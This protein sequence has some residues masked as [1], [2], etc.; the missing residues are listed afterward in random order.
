MSVFI[1]GFGISGYRSFGNETQRIAPLDKINL[2]I[3]QNNSEIIW[4][5]YDEENKPHS[6]RSYLSKQLAEKIIA[7]NSLSA[8]DLANFLRILNDQQQLSSTYSR[9]EPLSLARQILNKISPIQDIA[10]PEIE[11]IPAIRKIGE[12]DSKADDYSGLGI[13]DTLAKLQN[14]PYNQQG[15]KEKF[16]QI[17]E[18][19]REVIDNPTAIL[20]IPYERDMILVHMDDKTLPLSS[21]GMGIHEV[22]ILGAAATVLEEQIICIEELEIHLHPIL[23][24]KLIRYLRDRTSNQYFITTHSAHLLDTPGAAIFHV[25]YQNGQSFVNLVSS[26]ND[27]TLIC[28]DLGYHASDLLQANCIIWVEGPSDRIYLKYWIESIDENLT[29]GIHY[30]IMFYGGRLLSHLSGADEFDEDEIKEFINLKK[31]NRYSAIMIDSDKDS[32]RKHI[33]QTK[34]RIKN[35][36]ES[37]LG[38]AWITQGREVENYID[39]DILEAA[40]KKVH[41][42]AVALEK[43]GNYD[44]CLP[45]INKK[46]KINSNVN[47][48]KVAREVIERSPT[49]DILDLKSR[50]NQTVKFIKVSNGL[51]CN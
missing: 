23:Q 19:V 50:I 14:P 48:V 39:P 25:K 6:T 10:L 44:N 49:L 28:T 21:L 27:K 47:K 42:S 45:F 24:K 9:E 31:L 36:F 3:G 38:F 34:R 4:L 22:I 51:T 8:R 32:S 11:L 33:N 5:I 29:E 17:N 41:P 37:D 2:F 40:V 1:E 13:I 12:A 16:K 43:K 30:S 20:E 26:P 15:T 35:E 18:F 46:G 7:E